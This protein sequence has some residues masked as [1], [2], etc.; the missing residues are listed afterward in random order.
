MRVIVP[1][2][3]IL[4]VAAQLTAQQP[5]AAAHLRR[6]YAIVAVRR[7]VLAVDSA[8]AHGRLAEHIDS[9]QCNDG[10]ITLTG[11]LF[12]DSAGHARKY[13]V[14]GGSGDSAGDATYYYDLHGQ[15]RFA[16]S[17]TNTVHGAR[18][19]DRVYFDSTGSQ[20]Y[21]DTRRAH[22]PAYPGGFGDPVRDPKADFR[23]LCGPAT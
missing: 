23:A 16:F 4:S 14:E 7:I 8:A 17:H 22:G 11:H 18:Q 6:S 5:G 1:T 19:E 20:V 15:L 9:A 10:D 12:T 13:M 21:K 2:L 3:L